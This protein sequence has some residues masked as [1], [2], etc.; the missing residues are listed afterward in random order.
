MITVR[1]VRGG[2]VTEHQKK[3]YQAW[4]TRLISDCRREIKIQKEDKNER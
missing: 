3:L 4:V 1:I 2:K